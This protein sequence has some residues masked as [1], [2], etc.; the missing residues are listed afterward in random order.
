MQRY[1]ASQAVA[2]LAEVY[3]RDINR[4]MPFRFVHVDHAKHMA[5]LLNH[6]AQ[7]EKLQVI[8]DAEGQ[9]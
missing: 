4:R 8:R 1:E 7:E 2:G 6:A 3:D 9:S 5:W